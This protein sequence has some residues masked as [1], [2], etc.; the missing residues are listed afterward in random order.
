MS[1]SYITTS[2]KIALIIRCLLG[3]LNLQT[4]RADNSACGYTYGCNSIWQMHNA[5]SKSHPPIAM[6]V[7]HLTERST[8]AYGLTF[9]DYCVHGLVPRAR[10]GRGLPS[11]NHAQNYGIATRLL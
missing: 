1:C 4:A 8:P 7:S 9:P 3:K 5:T 6:P 11:I 2:K 10:L